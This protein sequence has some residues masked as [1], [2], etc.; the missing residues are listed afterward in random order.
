MLKNSPLTLPTCAC[1][2]F[3]VYEQVLSQTHTLNGTTVEVK[4]AVPKTEMGQGRGGMGMGMGMGMGGYGG[5]GG[6]GMGMGNQ[7]MQP[8]VQAR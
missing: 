4:R 2:Y 6:G 1:V 5:Y 7:N 8:G 3:R